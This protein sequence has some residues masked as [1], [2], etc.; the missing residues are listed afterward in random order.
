MKKIAVQVK[1]AAFGILVLSLMILSGLTGYASTIKSLISPAEIDILGT[2]FNAL[3]RNFIS[4]N[5][6]L[7]YSTNIDSS[8]PG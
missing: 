4:D 1:I 6:C 3:T 5:K 8:L 7:K 2:G